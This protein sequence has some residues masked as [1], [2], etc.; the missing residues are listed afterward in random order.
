[1]KFSVQCL[2]L[3][4][5]VALCLSYDSSESNESYEDLFMH[6]QQANSFINLPRG[7][8]PRRGVKSPAERQTEICEDYSPC[9]SY[10]YRHGYQTAYKKYF[11]ARTRRA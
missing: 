10:A 5:L 9:R 1:M 2:V 11:A 8:A 4:T 6:Q 3:A 7:N